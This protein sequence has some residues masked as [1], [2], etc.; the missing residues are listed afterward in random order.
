MKAYAG[1]Q[2]IEEDGT[3]AVLLSGISDCIREDKEGAGCSLQITRR[4]NN[5]SKKQTAG[6]YC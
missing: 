4:L 3:K 5:D 6:V 1:V 2:V